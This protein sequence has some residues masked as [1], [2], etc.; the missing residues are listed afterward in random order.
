M[1]YEFK[2]QEG[3]ER[4]MNKLYGFIAGLAISLVISVAHA[5]TI[6]G[7]S[8]LQAAPEQEQ[9]PDMQPN[10]G[11]SLTFDLPMTAKCWPIGIIKTLLERQYGQQAWA[12]GYNGMATQQQ[13]PFD[14]MVIA[15]HPE[16]FDYTVMIVSTA[17]NMAC[18]VAMGTE[19][20]LQSEQNN[21]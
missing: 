2:P 1:G 6:D 4:T 5:Q 8:M 9:A 7:N 13:S 10:Q 11:Q 20:H 21:E 16:T 14:G 17:N 18:V 19:L 15:R 12:L 3:K